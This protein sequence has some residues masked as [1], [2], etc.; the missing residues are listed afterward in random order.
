MFL[1]VEEV[2]L[3]RNVCQ[4]LLIGRILTSN[5][6]LSKPKYNNSSP[7]YKKEKEKIMRDKY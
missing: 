6:N 4:N 7:L 2:K 3:R 5:Y 1:K